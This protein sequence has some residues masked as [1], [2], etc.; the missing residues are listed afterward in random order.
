MFLAGQKIRQII[1]LGGWM[2]VVFNKNTQKSCNLS[3]STSQDVWLPTMWN[4]RCLKQELYWL[5]FWRI[6]GKI[7]KTKDPISC[8]IEKF[9]KN[10]AGFSN[11]YILE[12]ICVF[13]YNSCG[14][15]PRNKTFSK[16]LV[17]ALFSLFLYPMENEIDPLPPKTVVSFSLFPTP[18]LFLGQSNTFS[19]F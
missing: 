17:F 4:I 5:N 3:S 6:L 16:M 9:T 15:I 8:N 10:P 11:F 13:L 18:I 2:N 14:W 19:F 7:E 12:L 1:K